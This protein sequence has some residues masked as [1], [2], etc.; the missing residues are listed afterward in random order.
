MTVFAII[1]LVVILL[2]GQHLINWMWRAIGD[3]ES[4]VAIVATFLILIISVV[5]IRYIILWGYPVIT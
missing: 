1:C 5:C 2:V 4:P 3:T